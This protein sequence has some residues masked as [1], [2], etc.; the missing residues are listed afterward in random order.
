MQ[1]LEIVEVGLRDGLQDQPK[2]VPAPERLVVLDALVRAGI[3]SL[4][5]GSFVRPDRVPQMA[6]SG[7]VF[8]AAPTY[9]DVD[10]MALVPNLTGARAAVSA[11]ARSIKFVLSASDGHSRSNTGRSVAE[12]IAE[13]G[14]VAEFAVREGLAASAAIATAF[15]CPF[16]GTIAPQT[17]VD[18]GGKLSDFGYQSVSI[19]DTLGKAN[20]GQIR[21][22]V[23]QVMDALTGV[24]VNL[25]LHDT[26]GM[27]LANALAGLEAGVR[28]FDASVAGLGGC[29]FAPGAAGNIAT[30][31]LVH[32]THEL[33]YETGIDLELLGVAVCAICAAADCEPTSALARVHGWRSKNTADQSSTTAEGA[34]LTCRH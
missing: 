8:A 3:R 17:V 9:P 31:D 32:M 18:I 15:V 12:G 11:G 34:E 1:Q 14:A 2:V 24:K 6:A 27:G 5:L 13:A 4:E 20:P 22:T 29:P 33:G 19:A 30:E 23:T 10:L 16:D 21:Q 7:E 28:S 25:H 26:Y